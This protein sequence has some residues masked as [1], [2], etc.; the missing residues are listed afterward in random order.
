MFHIWFIHYDTLL[1]NSTDII[2]SLFQ[3]ASEFLL[4]NATILL[5]N[6]TVITKCNVY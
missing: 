1:Q 3:N 5:Q 2:K 4:Q 6:M